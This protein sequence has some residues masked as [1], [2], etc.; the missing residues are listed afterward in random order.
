ME[1]TDQLNSV[2]VVASS[3]SMLKTLSVA[4]AKQKKV[5]NHQK[6]GFK[7]FVLSKQYHAMREEKEEKKKKKGKQVDGCFT[8]FEVIER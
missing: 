7:I 8:S 6:N 5:I 1:T 2:F 3:S 4:C